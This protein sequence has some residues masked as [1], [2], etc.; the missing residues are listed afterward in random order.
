MRLRD[1]VGLVI[2][3]L[4]AIGIAFLTRIFLTKEEKQKEK[5][6]AQQAI[7]LNKILV[8]GKNLKEGDIIHLGD[9]KWESWPVLAMEPTFIKQGILDIQSLTGSVV[10]T[11][12]TRGEPVLSD[13]LI[14]PGEK[15]ILAALISPGMRAISIDVTAQSVS[16]G[17][18]APGD[19]VDVIQSKSGQGPGGVPIVES[20]TIVKNVKVLAV[21]LELAST[22]EKP[23]TTP[24]VVTLEVTPAQAEKISAAAKEGAVSL[25]LKS[26]KKGKV[27][28]E[29][30][31]KEEQE[32]PHKENLI[33]LRRGS[34]KSEIQVQE[35]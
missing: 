28:E 11:H 29:T 15:G 19:H 16:S 9:L 13:Y 35:Q 30:P 20:R 8:A 4:L 2:A 7:E 1:I 22:H 23:K 27:Y 10:R 5:A 14:K 21:D 34:E 32:A 33:I 24:K 17:L 3:L 12:I 31:A 18:I 6:E 25:S 26:I